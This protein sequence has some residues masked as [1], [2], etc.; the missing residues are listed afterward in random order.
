YSYLWDEAGRDAHLVSS[1]GTDRTLRVSDP[2]LEGGFV[3]RTW[4]VNADNECKLCHDGAAKFVLGFT[5]NQLHR[6][7]SGSGLDA[8]EQLATLVAQGVVSDSERLPKTDPARL[9]DPSDTT[10]SLDDRARS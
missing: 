7:S 9:V 5:P 4:H 8:N 6:L 2:N 1:I 10:Q 3:E